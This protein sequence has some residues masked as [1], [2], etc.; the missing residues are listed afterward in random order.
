MYSGVIVTLGYLFTKS[1]FTYKYVSEKI[2]IVS[3]LV[4]QNIF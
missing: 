1:I 2:N 4:G 3:A